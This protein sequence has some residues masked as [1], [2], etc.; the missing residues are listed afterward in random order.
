LKGLAM[1]PQEELRHVL[2]GSHPG[3]QPT[4]AGLVRIRLV[5]SAPADVLARSREVM[6]V[7]LE[8]S[9]TPWP[10]AARWTELLPEWFVRECAP[11]DPAAEQTWLEQWRGL[12]A[13]GR[14][15]AEQQKRWTL[16]S[17]LS[18][19]EPDEREWF[20][21]DASVADSEGAVV[22]D[23]PG[24]PAPFGALGWL[25]RASGAASVEVLDG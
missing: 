8:T 3:E 22:V 10:T 17:W 15:R 23:V 1:I 7:V 25:L 18:W 11:D 19:L 24:W 16:E 6:R 2:H 12:D 5:S 20:W 4:G 13:A 14:S 21:W 9:D